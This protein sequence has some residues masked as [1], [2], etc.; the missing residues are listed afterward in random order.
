MVKTMKKMIKKALM[1]Y[2]AKPFFVGSIPTAI[3][4]NGEV[5]CI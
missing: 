3:S 5:K 4:L 2:F 1:A